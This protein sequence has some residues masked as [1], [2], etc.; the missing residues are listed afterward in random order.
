MNH[1]SEMIDINLVKGYVEE[2]NNLLGSISES[3]RF[4]KRVYGNKSRECIDL[5]IDR[6]TYD[7]EKK[8]LDGLLR[9]F[10]GL[11]TKH[12]N[13]FSF[14]PK[15]QF[16]H[17]LC[18]SHEVVKTGIEVIESAPQRL[19]VVKIVPVLKSVKTHSVEV[20]PAVRIH[21]VVAKP[22]QNLSRAIL[23]RAIPRRVSCLQVNEIQLVKP[24]RYQFALG[25]VPNVALFPVVKIAPFP[26]SQHVIIQKIECTK[27]VSGVLIMK[28]LINYVKA[29][30]DCIQDYEKKRSLCISM[31]RYNFFRS[32]KSER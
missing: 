24:I 15:E 4:L 27:P 8:R 3:T 32:W 17:E 9:D 13:A 1:H 23:K 19:R 12:R 14:L 31:F 25:L 16:D 28:D 26:T 11:S 21:K 10:E 18:L 20:V 22:V 29:T 6:W 7:Y 5:E 30:T 2:R